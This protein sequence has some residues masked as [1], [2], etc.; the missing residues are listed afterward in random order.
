[1][2]FDHHVMR[3]TVEHAEQRKERPV[4]RVGHAPWIDERRKRADR[5]HRDGRI[6]ENEVGRFLRADAARDHIAKSAPE[7]GAQRDKGR[8][9]KSVRSRA[10]NNDDTGKADDNGAPASP[11]YVFRQQNGCQRRNNQRAGE[12]KCNCVCQRHHAECGD[13]K[14]CRSNETQCTKRLVADAV[15]FESC[16]PAAEVKDDN[17]RQ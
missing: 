13:D 9:L 16:E 5:H 17:Q 14:E 12:G 7:G 10:G 8:P 4:F 3:P 1:M 6:K 11:T 2:R 15:W